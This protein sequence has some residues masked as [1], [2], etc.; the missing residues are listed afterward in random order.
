M[1][2][3][4]NISAIICDAIVTGVMLLSSCTESHDKWNI[5]PNGV[6]DTD[7]ERDQL[8]T[9]AFFSQMQRG[10][11]IVGKDEGGTYQ[12]C[13][14]LTGD[15]FAGYFANIKASYD[16]VGSQHHDHYRM[17]SHWYDMPFNRVYNDIMQPWREI[18]RLPQNHLLTA[19]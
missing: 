1:K 4:P 12:I 13:Q 3:I 8:R 11:F 6:T 19:H 5:D 15:I 16:N 7:L 10:V 17:A 14:M 9:G 18:A 2:R